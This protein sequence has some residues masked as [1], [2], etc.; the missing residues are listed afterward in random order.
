MTE[1]EEL[2]EIIRN[3]FNNAICFGR[4]SDQQTWKESRD[5]ALD[6]YTDKILSIIAERCWLKDSRFQEPLEYG[7][8]GYL[9]QA[10][11]RPVKPIGE[12]KEAK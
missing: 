10:G 11:W 8:T 9:W 12:T 2:R 6:T 3:E 4:Y 1:Y 5:E 7:F